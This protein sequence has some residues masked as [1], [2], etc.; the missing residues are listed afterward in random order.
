MKQ[1]S[2]LCISQ[3]YIWTNSL[4]SWIKSLNYK[5]NTIRIHLLHLCIWRKL[6]NKHIVQFMN[7]HHSKCI[8]MVQK[9]SKPKLSFPNG[10]QKFLAFPVEN[11]LEKNT[12]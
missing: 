8:K 4:L 3:F 10:E 12:W 5:I 9:S 1:S 2:E 11:L 6:F 7:K